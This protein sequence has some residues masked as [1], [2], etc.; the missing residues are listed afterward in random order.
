MFIKND[1]VFKCVN[2]G[3]E[4][5]KL[6]YTSRDH[7]KYCLYSI[8]VDITPG[9]RLNECKGILKPICVVSK[10]K[11]EQIEYICQKCGKHIK[12][13]IALDDDKD[14]LYKIMQEYAKNGGK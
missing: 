3:R 10:G 14:T 2:C 11:K 1:E 8:H 13:V 6:E 5:P 7:C 4:V 12:N 9:D